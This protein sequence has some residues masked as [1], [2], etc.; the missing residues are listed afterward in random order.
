M[1]ADEFFYLSTIERIAAKKIW[2]NFNI[3]RYELQMLAGLSA[4]LQMLGRK[5]ISRDLFVDWLGLNFKA[6]RKVRM[7]L[8]GLI[9]KGVLHR[10]AYRRPDGNCLAISP[11]GIRVLEAYYHELNRIERQDRSRH[12]LPGYE[13]L[14][15]DLNNIPNGYTLKQAGRDS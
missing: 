5:I 9:D 2:K 15:V 14:G 4:R 10:L 13:S 8:K 7:Y 1:R 11:Y 6:E 3:N 12:K